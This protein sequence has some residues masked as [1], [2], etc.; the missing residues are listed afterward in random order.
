MSMTQPGAGFT[1]RTA[2]DAVRT[3]T[4]GATRTDAEQRALTS[5]L[6]GTLTH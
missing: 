4:V 6:R 5:D 2:L 3:T 1:I